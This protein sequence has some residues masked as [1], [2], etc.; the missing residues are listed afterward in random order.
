DDMM[1]VFRFPGVQQYWQA[2]ARE[3][4]TADFVDLIESTES[5]SPMLDWNEKEGFFTSKHH[6]A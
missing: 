4:F 1:G 5:F 6:Q 3:H 2:G